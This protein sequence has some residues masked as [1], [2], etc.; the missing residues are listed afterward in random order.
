MSGHSADIVIDGQNGQHAEGDIDSIHHLFETDSVNELDPREEFAVPVAVELCLNRN[1]RQQVPKVKVAST[2]LVDDACV[3]M[4]HP[5]MTYDQLIS[6]IS[7][8][9]ARVSD[10]LAIPILFSPDIL[11]CIYIWFTSYT[12]PIREPLDILATGVQWLR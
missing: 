12:K 6:R 2:R 10:E 3:I 4:I 5:K 11:G 1:P 8:S 7:E 9:L